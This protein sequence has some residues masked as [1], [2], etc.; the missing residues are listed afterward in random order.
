MKHSFK[1]VLGVVLIVGVLLAACA[2]AAAPAPVVQTVVVTKEVEKVVTQ[3]VVKTVE[4]QATPAPDRIPVYWYIGLGAGSQPAQIPLEKAFVDKFNASQTEIQLISQIVDNRYA[5]DNLTAQL[6]AGN[7]PDI[8]GPVGTAGRAAFPG[9]FFDIAEL[10]K[11]ANY[12]PGD[13]DPAFLDF[14]KVEGKLEGLPF[15]IFPSAIFVNK[16]LF[17]QAGLPY[18][19]Q[20]VG[21]KYTLDGKEL[22]WDFTTVAQVA[23]KLTVDKNGNDATSPSF[24]AKSIVQWG[25][26][27]Q[28]NDDPRAFG[29][30]FCAHYPVKDGKADIP[31]C[32]KEAWKWY[33]EAMWGKQPF[34]PNQA[35][36][37]SD[38]LKGNAFSSGKVAMGET[39]LWYTCC[40][41]TK[42][43]KNLDVA[44]APS[45]NGKITAK[46]HG[47]TFAIMA[48][49]KNPDAAFK[50]YTYMLGD[51]AQELYAIYGGLPARKSQQ[52]EFLKGL[53]DKF[54]KVN[55]QVF[56]DMIPFLDA[57]NHE[58][59]L[60]N[61]AK[62]NDAF[63]KLGGDL[64][65]NA[66][67]DLDT[68]FKQ[69]EDELN[70]IYSEKPAAQ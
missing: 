67:L 45:Y 7:A 13:I 49:S 21:D 3:E 25:F 46:M 69:F 39:H 24:D 65:S 62:A 59:G 47:D 52:A 30:F 64:R 54:G 35:A 28:W 2:P 22:D 33:Y 40:I 31:D 68:R 19:P 9:Q 41:D 56:L 34:M 23:R 57:P 36:T 61:N 20:K 60:P 15:A 50:V 11:K 70:Q 63:N 53:T 55:W 26:N 18:P 8:V 51:G 27:M 66:K 4:V 5:R 17:D 1:V 29:S 6:A 16:D 14:Y 10:M 44:I 12:D 43:V 38:L 42:N 48:Q 37:D 58:L 32:W